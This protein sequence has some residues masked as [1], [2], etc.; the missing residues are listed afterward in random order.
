MG[1]VS[2]YT[3]T[4]RW[5]S[6]TRGP[7]WLTQ[8]RGDC[9]SDKVKAKTDIQSLSCDILRRVHAHTRKHTNTCPHIS[10]ADNLFFSS[11]LTWVF[12]IYISIVIP[13]PGFQANIPLTPPLPL[14]SG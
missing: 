12:L 10:H 13:F 7:V 14:L 11:L 9:V 6:E 5:N 2:R 1:P 8:W 3:P 4:G